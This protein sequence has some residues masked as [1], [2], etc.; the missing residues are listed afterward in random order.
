MDCLSCMTTHFLAGCLI[1]TR[2]TLL[3]S[4]LL[5]WS[6]KP[7]DSFSAA[8]DILVIFMYISICIGFSD[9]N[10]GRVFCMTVHFLAYYMAH[11]LH[12]SGLIKL[13]WSQT[14]FHS[15][16]CWCHIDHLCISVL[17]SPYSSLGLSDSACAWFVVL[18]VSGHSVV[19]ALFWLV[20]VVIPHILF[21][22][23]QVLTT[24][25][26]VW[27]ILSCCGLSHWHISNQA[28]SAELTGNTGCCAT[29]KLC[30]I[31]RCV[32]VTS[33]KLFFLI[34][35]ASILSIVKTLTLSVHDWRWVSLVFP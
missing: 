19:F 3:G 5:M 21:T 23:F 6:Q 4:S 16:R 17:E 11:F 7:V 1:I 30:V 34:A 8:Y 35:V 14:Y 13:M 10:M 9:V 15:F 25:Y 24:V 29:Q 22:H 20:A 32:I 27:F 2:Y 26:G 31:V 28:V 33:D 12:Y 18:C